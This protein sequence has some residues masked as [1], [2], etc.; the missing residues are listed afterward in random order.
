MPFEFEQGLNIVYND[1][2][3]DM[4]E[5]LRDYEA[6]GLRVTAVI[7]NAVPLDLEATLVPVGV[8]GKVLDHISVDKVAVAAAR[9]GEGLT[10]DAAAVD[11][12]VTINVK[13]QNPADLKKLDRLRF[14][15]A[16][17]ANAPQGGALR[18]DQF[19]QVKDMRLR[20][21]GQIIGNFN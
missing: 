14:R 3:V 10:V 4:N 18:S 6:D 16:A 7:S 13:F 9:S 11:S 15:V 21:T 8:D 19:I 17:A 1:S 12:E 2:V 20:L 5:D